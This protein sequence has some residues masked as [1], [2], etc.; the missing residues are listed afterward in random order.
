MGWQGIE[1]LE[2]LGEGAVGYQHGGHAMLV[3]QVHVFAQ[4]SVE[5]RFSIERNSDVLWILGVQPL[6]ARNLGVSTK[7]REEP[8][9]SAYG[10]I[11]KVQW[12]L[13]GQL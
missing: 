1:V 10:F 7:A 5:G 2:H 12:V 13:V 9:L 4:A 6:F 3:A 11:E 8:A